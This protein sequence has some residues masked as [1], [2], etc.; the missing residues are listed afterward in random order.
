MLCLQFCRL[1]P[2]RALFF[3]MRILGNPLSDVL[4]RQ[5]FLIR[6]KGK[7]SLAKLIKEKE[8]FFKQMESHLMLE[9]SSENIFHESL[10]HTL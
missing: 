5:R 10:S 7:I 1:K 3:L 9:F 2:E 6:T 4:R 8:H